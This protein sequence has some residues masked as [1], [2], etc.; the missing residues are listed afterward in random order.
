VGEGPVPF[1]RGRQRGVPPLKTLFIAIGF[2]RVKTVADLLPMPRSGVDWAKV[3]DAVLARME[4]MTR[5]WYMDR[6]KGA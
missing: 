2:Y 5:T 6:Y 4:T 3:Y 1:E